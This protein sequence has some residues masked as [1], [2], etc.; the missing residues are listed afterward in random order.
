MRVHAAI[1]DIS[2]KALVVGSAELFLSH[3]STEQPASLRRMAEYSW[4]IYRR[5]GRL[6]RQTVV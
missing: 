4:A 2:L 6:P 5:E 3:V 1:P